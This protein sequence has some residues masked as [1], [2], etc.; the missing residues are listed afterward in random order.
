[1]Y[2]H[3]RNFVYFLHVYYDIKF[4]PVKKENYIILNINEKL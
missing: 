4:Q 3:Q 2:L 1:M